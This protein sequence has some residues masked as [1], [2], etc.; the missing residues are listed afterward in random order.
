MSL[1]NKN[2][3]V[4]ISFTFLSVASLILLSAFTFLYFQPLS[5]AELPP[6]T[7]CAFKYGEGFSWDECK[8]VFLPDFALKRLKET[9]QIDHVH[10]PCRS[11]LAYT[12]DI[13]A[14]ISYCQTG[15]IFGHREF[16]LGPSGYIVDIDVPVRCENS[17]IIRGSVVWEK[18]GEVDPYF[19]RYL[20][21]TD[22]QKDCLAERKT[23]I[24]VYK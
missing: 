1:Y 3:P 19:S 10:I 22:F 13:S 18:D 12:P 20:H 11:Y 17:V 24:G 6:A 21:Y 9:N 2:F 7:T 4:K 8:T 23:R 15:G 14:R 5:A 16:L